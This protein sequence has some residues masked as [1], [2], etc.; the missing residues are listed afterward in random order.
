[1]AAASVRAAQEL[2][3][4]VAITGGSEI[5][6]AQINKKHSVVARSIILRKIHVGV[7]LYVEDR[8]R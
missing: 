6:Q 5:L 2:T 7:G 4:F 8:L 3:F 1:M